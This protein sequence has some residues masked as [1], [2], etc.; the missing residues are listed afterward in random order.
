MVIYILGSS[1]A[2]GK[3]TYADHYVWSYDGRGGGGVKNCL[4]YQRGIDNTQT[5]NRQ[6]IDKAQTRYIQ[7]IDKT[8]TRHRQDID[9]TQLR[10]RQHID[11]TQASHRQYIYKRWTRHRQDME[12]AQ[13]RNRQDLDN[14]QTT[15]RGGELK[16][17]IHTDI[18][19]DR[20][21]DR[22]SDEAGP[23]G[24]FAPNNNANYAPWSSLVYS[25]KN[26]NI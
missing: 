18:Q 1:Y 16:C 17:Y 12:K 13:T 6:D 2:V 23:R 25:S 7:D 3:S 15:Q 21:T 4:G 8:Q 20:Q 10:H 24:A 11:N 5:R 26:C 9:K 14:I 19:T 22:P